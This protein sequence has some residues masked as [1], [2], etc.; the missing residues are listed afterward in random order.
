MVDKDRFEYT[1]QRL[2]EGAS[3]RQIARELGVDKSTIHY[4][5]KHAFSTGTRAAEE[6]SHLKII[7]WC[8][9]HSAEY[10]YLLGC[11]LGDGHIVIM[12]RT[13][14]LSIYNDN[15]YPDII[16]DQNIALQKIFPNNK[17]TNYQQ[18]YSRCLE[19]NVHNKFL[20]KLFPQHGP[21]KKHDRD[22]SLQDWQW[23][24][25]WKEP[26]CFIKGLIDSDGSYYLQTQRNA[27]GMVHAGMRYQFTNKSL[28]IIDMYLIVMDK[29][30]ISVHPTTRKNGTINV[31]TQKTSEVEKLD[32]LYIIAENKIRNPPIL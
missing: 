30:N 32:K 3:Q 26:E 1:K 24:I 9:K 10:A 7:E 27:N 4:W 6:L 17:I 2:A 18:L 21:G 25:V 15:R 16:Q 22:V 12:P 28:D 29:L 8:N 5:I 14:K 31:L 13:Q 20:S 19:V 23:D 11:Y